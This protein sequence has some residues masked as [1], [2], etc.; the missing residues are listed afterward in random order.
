MTS[1]NNN[2]E[3]FSENQLTKLTNFYEMEI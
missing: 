1:G 2:F 3:C